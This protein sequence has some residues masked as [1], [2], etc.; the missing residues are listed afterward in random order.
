MWPGQKVCRTIKKLISRLPVRKLLSSFAILFV[1]VCLNI[2]NIVVAQSAE[3]AVVEAVI[4][5]SPNC[6]HCHH[7][8]NEV[9]IPLVDE[10]GEQ[11]QIVGIDT[12]QPSGAQ[13]YQASVEQYQVPSERRG[14]PTLIVGDVVLVGSVEIPEQFPDLV[15]QGLAA[16]GIAL[17]NIPGLEQVL[18]EA[19]GEA[20]PT[21]ALAETHTAPSPTLTAIPPAADTPPPS[22]VTAE[23]Q[24]TETPPPSISVAALLPTATPASSLL[25]VGKDEIA[26]DEDQDPPADPVGSALA[27]VVLAGLVVACVYAVWRVTLAR[28]R[29]VR[30]GGQ[31]S[32]VRANTWVIPLLAL[33]GLV[34]A[35]YLAYVETQQVKAVCGPVGECNIVQ[36]SDYARMLGIP[37]AV[38]GVLNY[39]AIGALWAGQ[40]YLPGRWANLSGLAL[41]GL[42]SFGVLFSIYLT[43][44][45]LFV[46]RAICAWCLCSAIVTMLT[47]FLVAD[48]IRGDEFLKATAP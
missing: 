25:T 2:T 16:G 31:E 44:L 13:L 17:P 32:I 9:L 46:I 39:L 23:I 3:E 40:R 35:S 7:V 27:G 18:A 20:T 19:Q 42:T 48:S 28:N 24:A 29:L 33:L 30:L 4:F 43:C 22:T 10:Y 14:V 1:V 21:A 11:L 37:V 12:S 15:E 6:S 5:Y 34:V 36:T 26:L 38:L 45:E 47:M 41:L 8:I